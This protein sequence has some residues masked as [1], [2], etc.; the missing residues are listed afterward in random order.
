M[1]G[2]AENGDRRFLGYCASTPESSLTAILSRGFRDA[3]AGARFSDDCE[4]HMR[5]RGLHGLARFQER[6]LAIYLANHNLLYTD[7]MGMAV[8]ARGARA[9]SGHENRPAVSDTP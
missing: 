7:K 4:S 5:T 1:T 8:R 2:L 3:L 9:L 6:D